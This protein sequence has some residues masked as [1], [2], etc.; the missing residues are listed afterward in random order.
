MDINDFY[1]APLY[2]ELHRFRYADEKT[3]VDRGFDLTFAELR[4]LTALTKL[5]AKPKNKN[6]VAKEKITIEDWKILGERPVLSFKWNQYYKAYYEVKA[7]GKV[8]GGRQTQIAKQ[9]LSGLCKKTLKLSYYRKEGLPTLT[10]EGPLVEERNNNSG[11]NRNRLA[12]AF[13]PIFI[14]NIKTFYILKPP[15]LLNQ[16]CDYLGCQ[17]AKK[18]VVLFIEWLLTKENPS[19]SI[20]KENLIERLWL[21]PLREERKTSMIEEILQEC[22]NTAKGLGFLR[23]FDDKDR[24]KNKSTKFIFKLNRDLCSRVECNK[25]VKCNKN[26]TG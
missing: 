6:D 20:C 4:A 9:A 10:F 7:E 21:Q 5:L 11:D 26:K 12:I 13:H 2:L 23:T 17:K 3:G 24:C 8:P 16:V 15:D 1:R 14:D 25:K 19:T 18:T 22:F